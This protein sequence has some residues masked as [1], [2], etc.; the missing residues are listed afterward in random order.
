MSD[1]VETEFLRPKCSVKT[2]TGKT[3]R[4]IFQIKPKISFSVD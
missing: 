2:E 1:S 4:E 3:C